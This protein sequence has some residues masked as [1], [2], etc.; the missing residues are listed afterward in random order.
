VIYN[1]PP[2]PF[3]HLLQRRIRCRMGR[4]IPCGCPV[5]AAGYPPL[6]EVPEGRRRTL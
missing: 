4:G 6:E 5:C 2:P 3:G 1:H